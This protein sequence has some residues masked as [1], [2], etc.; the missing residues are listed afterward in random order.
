MVFAP[1][2]LGRLS[3]ESGLALLIAAIVNLHHFVLDGAIW[4]LRDGRVGRILLRGVA[5]EADGPHRPGW[6]ARVAWALGALSIVYAGA[7]TYEDH[8][9]FQR[10]L[11]R[12]ALRRATISADRFAL[13]GRDA[14]DRRLR[15]GM[16]LASDGRHREALVQFHRAIGLEPSVE[17][18]R[19][20]A[21]IYSESGDDE[22]AI[23]ALESALALDLDDALA[24]YR[25]GVAQLR[26]GKPSLAAESL[27]RADELSP[28]NRN[29]Q[30]ALRRARLR[31]G[32]GDEAAGEGG[33]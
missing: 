3:Y 25:I 33:P 32:T 1:G 31:L 14:S 21:R 15:L 11:E 28:D 22:R 2:L 6:L 30:A 8:V 18:W 23:V 12:G 16:H 17:A 27:Q 10:A 29:V 26:L 20:V 13:I 24:H 9:G 19:S 4:K 5:S 7:T